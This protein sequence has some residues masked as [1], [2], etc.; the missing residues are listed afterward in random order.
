MRRV[1]SFVI[2]GAVVA[3]G[4]LRPAAGQE[5]VLADPNPPPN[6][7]L[8]QVLWNA[9]KVKLEVA[10]DRQQ[11]LSGEVMRVT[12]GAF[13]PQSGPVEVFDPLSV[14][15]FEIQQWSDRFK[16]GARNW[17]L[18]ND[19]QIGD[20]DW[21]APRITLGPGQSVEKQAMFSSRGCPECV[22]KYT[23]QVE[24]KYLLR[25]CFP[26]RHDTCA[27]TEFTVTVPLVVGA[28]HAE[29]HEPDRQFDKLT[30]RDRVRPLYFNALLLEADGKRYVVVSRERSFDPDVNPGPT[31]KIAGVLRQVEPYDRIAE[32]SPAV[33]AIKLEADDRDNLTVRWTDENGQPHAHFLSADRSRIER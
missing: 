14:A 4:L 2:L 11:Y 25:Y 24:G 17:E 21:K 22:I 10:L 16:S 13:N 3:T 12:Y 9:Q 29:R 27:S 18:F 30:G 31:R 5:E 8:R 28:A 26:E 1:R 7:R 6:T 33:K 19:D 23:P 32:V 15:G 20:L